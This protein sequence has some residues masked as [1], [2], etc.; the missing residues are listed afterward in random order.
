MKILWITNTIFPEPSKF[1]GFENPVFGGWMYGLA[2]SLSKVPGIELAVATTY[3]GDKLK[4]T[5]INGVVYYMLP[6]KNNHK[7]DKSLE[8]IWEEVCETFKPEVVHIH[9]TEFVH[10]LACMRK[11]PNLNYVISIQG[12]LSVISMHYLSGLTTFEVLKN[13]TFRDMIRNDNLFQTKSKFKQRGFFEKEYIER[14]RHVIGRTNWDRIH[15]QAVNENV[16]YHFC[17][18]SLRN[19]FYSCNKWILQNSVKHTIFISQ[20]SYPIKGLH[21]VIRA[22]VPLK[23]KYPNIQLRVGGPNIIL[24]TTLMDKIKFSGYGKYIY[25]LL[26]KYNLEKNII[27]LGML[28]EEDMIVEYQKANVFICPSS[29]ENSPNSLG[30]AQIIGVPTISSYVGG[31]PDMVENN[32]SGL[33][34]RFEE[35]EML[36]DGIS[37]IFSNNELVDSLSSNGVLAAEFRHNKERNLEKIIKIYQDVNIYE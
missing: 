30:E 12:L 16:N 3:K 37:N 29:I 1:F 11:L 10:G 19:S 21:Q 34:Y 2:E 32:V 22:I 35:V 17:N 24:R 7:Y 33:L 20:A 14:T 18:E 27:F 15:I 13:I 4:Y 6:C 23:S 5:T 25:K 31:I 8:P 26:K 36:S 28:S 9:G